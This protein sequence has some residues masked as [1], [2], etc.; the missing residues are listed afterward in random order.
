MSRK[1]RISDR[2]RRERQRTQVANLR[3]AEKKTLASGE[4]M[5]APD[6][7][8]P[9]RGKTSNAVA[10]VSTKP[11]E[12]IPR[13]RSLRLIE[14]KSKM[15]K[16]SSDAKDADAI[17]PQMST[18]R[19]R[20]LSRTNSRKKRSQNRNVSQT[21]AGSTPTCPRNRLEYFKNLRKRKPRKFIERG[22]DLQMKQRKV[23]TEIQLRNRRMNGNI[24]ASRFKL[25]CM[26]LWRAETFLRNLDSKRN[27]FKQKTVQIPCQNIRRINNA[28]SSKSKS[29]FKSSARSYAIGR[30]L[31]FDGETRTI[32]SKGRKKSKPSNEELYFSKIREAPD[33]VCSCCGGLFYSESVKY[34]KTSASKLSQKGLTDEM[35]AKVLF[36]QQSQHLFC[37]TCKSYIY[38][39]EPKIPR[40][41][42]SNGLDFPTVPDVLKVHHILY[43]YLIYR[44][45]SSNLFNFTYICRVLIDWRRD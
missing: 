45:L 36:V 23:R 17:T 21:D 27:L 34:G 32:K 25:R 13:R 30:R 12:D 42:L 10:G 44:I 29:N 35:I 7:R 18:A 43:A 6:K 20:K 1:K 3:Q 9:K 41:A 40:V 39:K 4:G 5:Q 33:N 22:A 19:K 11:L 38:G 15:V 24:E 26:S 28:S 31:D 8:S 14:K 16:Q 37:S 2:Q